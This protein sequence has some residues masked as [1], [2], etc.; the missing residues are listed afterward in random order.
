MLIQELFMV[1]LL[2]PIKFRKTGSHTVLNM[3]LQRRI[4]WMIY[5]DKSML[6]AYAPVHHCLEEIFL[7][8]LNCLVRACQP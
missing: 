5:A 6:L 3:Q 2:T 1:A 7:V 4:T 8:L